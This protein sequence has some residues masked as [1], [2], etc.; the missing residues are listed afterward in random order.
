MLVHG[1]AGDASL[2]G[3]EP[4][5]ELWFLERPKL[6][7]A[8]DMLDGMCEGLARGG[9]FVCSEETLDIFTA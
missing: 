1:G 9:D 4:C 6:D 5:L 8:I 2:L 7:A 3:R